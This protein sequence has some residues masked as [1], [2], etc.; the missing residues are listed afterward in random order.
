MEQCMRE[1]FSW[2]EAG[3]LRP[4]VTVTYPLDS[5]AQALQDVVDRRANGRIVLV[6]S[7]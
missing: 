4:A 6:P 5:F 7:V 1:I 3:K 2:Y